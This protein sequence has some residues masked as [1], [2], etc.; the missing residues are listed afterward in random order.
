[1]KFPPSQENETQP[2]EKTQL[3]K[4]CPKCDAVMLK[5]RYW[6]CPNK[7]L[8]YKISLNLS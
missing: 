2:N 3:D 7:C 5:R 1:M 8:Y 6:Y 4:H